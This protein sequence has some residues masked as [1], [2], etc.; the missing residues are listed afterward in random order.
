MEKT[1]WKVKAIERSKEIKRLKKKIKE[2][3]ISRDDWKMKSIRHKNRADKSASDLKKIKN[4][5][6]EIV[7]Q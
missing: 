1:D 7:S 2:V 6:N 3:S 5:L 4:R